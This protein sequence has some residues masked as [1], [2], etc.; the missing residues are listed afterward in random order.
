VGWSSIAV[1]DTAGGLPMTDEHPRPDE[2][3]LDEASLSEDDS[4]L[5]VDLLDDP[6]LEDLDDDL[7]DY[8]DPDDTDEPDLRRFQDD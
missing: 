8:E 1:D 2:D 5:D 7:S 3:D 4:A 6:D